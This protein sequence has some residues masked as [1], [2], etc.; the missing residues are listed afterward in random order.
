MEALLF[1]GDGALDAFGLVDQFGEM[2]AH[3][4]KYDIGDLSQ[5]GAVETDLASEAGGSPYHNARNGGAPLG[6]G[7]NAVTDE[8]YG[9]ADMIGDDA[10]RHDVRVPLG[11]AM[12]SQFLRASDDGHEKIGF[13]G[14]FNALQHGDNSL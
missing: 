10:I 7:H 8:K 3:Q 5:E 13:V 14:G 1:Q 4:V 6:A 9:R 12:A 2:L 11:I